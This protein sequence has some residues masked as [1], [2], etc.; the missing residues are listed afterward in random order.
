MMSIVKFLVIIP[1]LIYCSCSSPEQQSEKYYYPAEWEAHEAIWIGYGSDNP[2]PEFDSVTLT[3]VS[4]FAK[5]VKVNLVIDNDSMISILRGDFQ[6]FDIDSNKVEFIIQENVGFFY[7]D[8]GPVFLTNKSGDL[9]IADMLWTGYANIHYDSISE[10]EQITEKFDEDIAERLG[11][12][13]TQSNV[14]MEGGAFE[15]NGKGTILQVEAVTL[16]RNPHL[17]KEEIEQDILNTLGQ[18]KVIW[19]KEGLA[20]DP[21]QVKHF[22]GKYYG[23]GTGG[24][25]DEFCRFTNDSTILLCWIPESE[26]D[27]NLL[28]QINFYRMMEN[29]IIL[30]NATDQDGNSFKI[31]K[32]PVPEIQFLESKITQQEFD[33]LKPVYPEL[34]LDDTLKWVAASSYLNY[35]VTNGIVLIPSYWQEG[36]DE[37]LRLKDSQVLEIFEKQFPTREVI[38]LNPIILNYYGGGMHCMTQQQ[39]KSGK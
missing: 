15:V 34:S 3:M 39:P 26:K 11:L 2:L 7:R 35:V 6:D 5:Q 21:H 1:L 8:P 9:K 33:F 28:N 18:R 10:Y 23:F 19:L 31:I 27:H 25:V 22:I 24:H 14:V 36:L 4:K 38:Q 20:E 16:N 13:T 32:V 30:S 17:S 37:S 12:E 29:F